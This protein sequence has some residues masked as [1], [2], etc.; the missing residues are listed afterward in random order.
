[1]VVGHG[2]FQHLGVHVFTHVSRNVLSD[3]DMLTCRKSRK[4]VQD[5]LGAHVENGDDE[6][7]ASRSGGAFGEGDA[8]INLLPHADTMFIH[9]DRPFHGA[10]ENGLF[11]CLGRFVGT[12][13]FNDE[14]LIDDEP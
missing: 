1:M 12:R 3:D 14:N 6:Q 11:R 4:E 5:R 8:L 7:A 13:R 9:M 2:Q 10:A